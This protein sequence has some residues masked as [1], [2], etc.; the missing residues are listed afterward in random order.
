[1]YGAVPPAAVIVLENATFDGATWLPGFATTTPV[2][3]VN[4]ALAVA[5]V[6][7]RTVTVTEEPPAAEGTPETTPVPVLMDSPVGRPVADQVY[8]EVP[9]AAAIGSDTEVPVGLDCA[10]GL[11]T[12][13][14]AAHAGGETKPASS[15]ATHEN[16]SST[17]ARERP[18]LPR[19]EPGALRSP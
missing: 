3:Q 7:S 13:S 4:E 10:P 9:P 14:A 18:W 11:V 8:G 1:M 5:V 12:D 15:A 16:A 6:A 2:A 17:I 19:G